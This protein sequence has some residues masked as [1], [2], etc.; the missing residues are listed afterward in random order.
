MAFTPGKSSVD[1]LQI[2]KKKEKKI[3]VEKLAGFLDITHKTSLN[4]LKISIFCFVSPKPFD[5]LYL[6]SRDQATSLK[7]MRGGKHFKCVAVQ[8]GVS[9]NWVLVFQHFIQIREWILF[10]RAMVLF[11]LQQFSIGLLTNPTHHN[12]PWILF[13]PL[14]K[15]VRDF[16]IKST[17]IF[18]PSRGGSLRKPRIGRQLLPSSSMQKAECSLIKN[19]QNEFS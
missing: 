5:L 15:N 8:K 17:W 19:P 2:K 14:N 3:A 4:R 18:F 10:L 13:F 9:R 7:H 11:S 16:F 12:D 1:S 6:I